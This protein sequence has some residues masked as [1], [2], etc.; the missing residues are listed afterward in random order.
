[1]ERAACR[2][3]CLLETE[4]HTPANIVRTVGM[5]AMRGVCTHEEQIA[6]RHHTVDRFIIRHQ[7]GLDHRAPFSLMFQQLLLPRNHFE[8][9]AAGID[10]DQRNPDGQDFRNVSFLFCYTLI[11]VPGAGG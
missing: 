10:I 6:A 8:T 5:T 1:M 4:I 9:T 2:G 3:A 11:L 7:M